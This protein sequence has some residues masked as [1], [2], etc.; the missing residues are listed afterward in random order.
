MANIPISSFTA[1]A[2]ATGIG[3]SG[4]SLTGANAQSMLDL[5]GT[6][7]TSGTP[8][9]LKLNVTDTAS[10]AASLLMDL[11]TGGVSRFSVRKDGAV[12][13]RASG[14]VEVY[15]LARAG[16]ALTFYNPSN[17]AFFDAQLAGVT[18]RENAAYSFSPTSD[19]SAG[20]DLR[21]FR[22][23]A[24]TLAQ[25]NGT[26]AQAFRVYNTYTDGSN[27]ERA[28]IAWVSN[29]LIIGTESAGTGSTNRTLAINAQNGSIAFTAGFNQCWTINSSSH[30]VTGVDNLFDIGASGGQRPRSI[31]AAADILAQNNT[32]GFYLGASA[33][34]AI[35]RDDANILAQRRGT[36]PQTFRVYN[37]STDASNYERGVFDWT[38]QSNALTIGTQQAGSG[39]ARSLRLITQGDG[40]LLFITNSVTRFDV[41]SLGLRATANL[42]W[43]ADNTYDIGASGA[44]RPRNIFAGSSL[45]IGDGGSVQFGTRAAISSPATN[46]V[47][48]TNNATSAGAAFELWEMTAPAAPN[49]D[50]VRIYAEDNGSGKTRLM[51]RFAT[52]AAVQIA[53][54][55]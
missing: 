53:I 8:T 47:V 50:R 23:A 21:L 44:N 39:I 35:L 7:N 34:V 10:N 9:G 52:G 29:Q 45:V 22:D 14:A 27:Y 36:N 6:W 16:N 19:A 13:F 20:A 48:P 49:T 46:V 17:L 43:T 32:S 11:Q 24:N 25:R 1:A 26:N 51:A 3:M 41:S 38:T 4:F 54:E 18:I 28:R 30:F 31:Y 33:D 40:N 37:T 2:N 55:P 5:A 15:A 12:Q 42:I